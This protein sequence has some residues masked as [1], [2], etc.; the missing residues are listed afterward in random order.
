MFEKRIRFN[1]DND[2]SF[3]GLKSEWAVFE[4]GPLVS[5][6]GGFSYRVAGTAGAAAA[7]VAGAVPAK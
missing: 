5:D 1:I 2:R 3:D 6:G 7:V 4:D